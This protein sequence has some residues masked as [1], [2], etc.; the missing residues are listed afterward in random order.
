MEYSS[1]D[2]GPEFEQQVLN[3]LIL[4]PSFAL[5]FQ[6]IVDSSAFS[7][8]NNRYIVQT[9]LDYVDEYGQVP[10]REVLADLVRKG[11]F[12]DKGGALQRIEEAS[13]VPDLEYV[14]KRILSW[15]KWTAIEGV[16]QS[17]NGDQPREFAQRINRAACIGDNLILGHTQLGTDQQGD[18]GRGVVIP[19]P[20]LWLNEQLDGGPEIGDLAVIL[21]V[22]GGGKTTALVNI[23]RHALS[24]GKFVV[25]FTFEDGERKIKRRLMQSIANATKDELI[26]DRKGAIRK[27]NRFLKKY[28]GKCEIK[29]LQSRRS[30]VEDAFSFVKTVEEIN[31]SSVDL[32]ITD[33]ADRFRPQGRYSEPR[34][35]LREIFE[36]CKWLARELNVV[37]WTARQTKITKV[38]KEIISTDAAGESWGSME[39]PDLVIGLGRTLEDEQLGRMTLYTAKVRDG[40][41]HQAKSLVTDFERQRIIDP[42]EEEDD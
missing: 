10:S 26:A 42:V 6:P 18:D 41:D 19:T 39:S 1:H 9:I 22:V 21:T 5:K 8:E 24:L 4:D 35:G 11:V 38:G 29:N 40:L 23:A 20:W 25:Y 3:V 30:G 7:F 33:Y 12:R 2:F 17:H 14:Q 34:H 13:P 36:D 37:H 27:R 32:V 28:G 16:L 15:A 31:E